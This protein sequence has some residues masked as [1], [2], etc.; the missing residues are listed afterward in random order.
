MPPPA[1]RNKSPAKAGPDKV[2]PVQAKEKPVQGKDN[3]L[4]AVAVSAVLT[5]MLS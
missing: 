2:R 4:N 3:G 1:K 5:R